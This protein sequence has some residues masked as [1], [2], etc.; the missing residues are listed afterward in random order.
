LDKFCHSCAVSLDRSE[1]KG[2]AENYC[3]YCANEAGNLK[4]KADVQKGIAHWFKTWQPGI[5]DEIAMRRAE[6]YMRSMPAW[7]DK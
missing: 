7:A 3:R 1:F 6:I 5:N 2:P 4:P